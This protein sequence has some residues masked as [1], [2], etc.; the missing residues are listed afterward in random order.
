MTH[1]KASLQDL[2]RSVRIRLDHLIETLRSV[3]GDDLHAVIA[4]G[5]A[6]RGGYREDESDVDLMIVLRHED[7]A[8][9]E[10][11]GPALQLARYSARIEA[12]L[13]SVAEIPRAADCFPLLYEDIAGC[14]VAL[15]GTSPF[16]SVPV[17]SEHRRLRIEQELREARIRLRRVVTDMADT[18]AF[19]RAVER[20]LK[21]LR[22]PLF[23]L[24]RLRGQQQPDQL[25]AVFD[26]VGRLYGLDLQALTQARQAPRPA[27]AAL[28]TLLD[29]A[30]A[31]VDGLGADAAGS[32]ARS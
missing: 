17:L 11:I 7:A 6:V 3:L 32:R 27:Y 12:M 25:E 5:S 16:A 21:Q 15:H 24:L 23:A 30:L 8:L 19:G 14:S 22:G 18:P 20:K 2:P 31:D 10:A 1:D 29:R 9:L 28:V 26:G 13:V 4:F